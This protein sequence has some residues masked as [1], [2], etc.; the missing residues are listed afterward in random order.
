MYVIE[1]LRILL[2]YGEQGDLDRLAHRRRDADLRRRRRRRRH[3]LLIVM[4]LV[5]GR[6][7]MLCAV[8]MIG[9]DRIEAVAPTTVCLGFG[10][11]SA[12][13]ARRSA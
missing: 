2:S 8:W 7:V 10:V 9:S 13:S 1:F 11:F 6:A 12:G 3:V 5:I 4:T